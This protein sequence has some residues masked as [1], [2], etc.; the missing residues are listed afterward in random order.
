MLKLEG[1]ELVL[2]QAEAITG[3][4]SVINKAKFD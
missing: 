2:I 3:Y 1:T 4:L